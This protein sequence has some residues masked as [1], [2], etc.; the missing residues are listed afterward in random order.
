MLTPTLVSSTAHGTLTFNAN[1]SLSYQPTAGYV[2]PDVF[3]YKVNDGLADSNTAFVSIVVHAETVAQVIGGGGDQPTIVMT[4]TEQD[5]ATQGD[6]LETTLTV[7]AGFSG[8]ASIGEAT[9]ILPTPAG[10]TLLDQQINI[11]APV[12]SPANPLVIAF[13]FD[14]SIVPAGQD[15]NTLQIFRNGVLVPGCLVGAGTAASPDPCVANRV[16]LGDGDVEITVRTSAAS[17]WTCGFPTAATNTVPTT[18]DDDGY[19]TSEDQ[20][21]SVAAPGVLFNDRDRENDP[22]TA[23][24]VAGPSPLQG[25]VTLGNDGAFLYTP[26]ANF[27]G[28]AT[29]TYR[30]TDGNPSNIATVKINVTAVNDTPVAQADNYTVA[31]GGTLAPPAPG[32]LANDTDPDNS[33]TAIRVSG[34]AHGALT[35]NANGSF[36]YTHDGSETTS[37]SFTYK[38]NDGTVDSNIVT[39]TISVAPADDAPVANGQAVST[40][41]DTPKAIALTGTDVESQ[42]LTFA[43]VGSPAHGSLSGTAPNLTYTPATNYNGPDSFTFKVTAGGVDSNVATVSITVTAVDDAPV[44]NGQAVSTNEDTPKALTLTGTDV[45][46]QALTFT[47]VGSPSHGSLSGTAPNLTY[48]PAANHNGPDS[49]TFKVTA[50]GVDS[51]LATVTISVNAVNDPPVAAN[52]IATVNEDSGTNAI[53]VLTNDTSAPDSGETLTITGKTNGANGTV[54][55]TGGGTGLTYAPNGNFNGSDS[56]TYTIA[57]GNGGTASGTV[58]VTVTSV[59]DLPTISNIANQSTAIGVAEGPLSFTIGDVET[60]AAAL[61]LGRSSSNT[62]L[63][64]TGNIVFGGSGANRTVTI[65]P[66]AGQTGTAI[67][68][69]TV[70]DTNG[71][72][73]NDTFVQTVVNLTPTTTSMPTT[74]LT[75][76]T[77]GQSVTFTATAS[78]AGGTPTGTMTFFDNGISL[79]TA[80]LNGSGAAS[81]AT[82][83]VAVGTR[84]ITA[85]Y[86]GNTQFAGST[87]PARTQTVNAAAAASTL[88][89]A[90][91][92]RQYRIFRPTK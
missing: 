47:V 81:L 27:N 45:E 83:L 15:A 67:I 30:I 40:N 72:S 44:A 75:P 69:V 88:T 43:V 52:D 78:G 12:A 22:F 41:E 28:L 87:S 60:S 46:G 38:V 48:T 31:E 16:L 34:P 24:L 20:P 73:A 23:V 37:D 77:Y 4:D 70:T 85:V 58:N 6:P 82:N 68:T 55:I 1:G 7:P 26:A 90:Q 10:F 80:T 9:A 51:N 86:N 61:T 65:T 53:N 56:F 49:F 21:L 35:L 91:I 33:L 17:A 39:V 74:S 62:T 71:G 5:G 54:V 64:P 42:A 92:T 25:S 57:D 29:F 59:N 32:V 19:T 13:R 36:S 11:T 79:G 2:G 84:S 8:T 66:A 18:F 3:T 76:S 63:V 50:G 89:I 14:A